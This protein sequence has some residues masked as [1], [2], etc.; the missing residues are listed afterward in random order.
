MKYAIALILACC[1]LCAQEK[2][3]QKKGAGAAAAR[4]PALRIESLS[5]F[6]AYRK[7]IC[8][9]YLNAESPIY[10]KG[11]AASSDE[12]AA[13]TAAAAELAKLQIYM[14]KRPV[15]IDA[16]RSGATLGRDSETMSEC[17]TK[18]FA[19]KIATDL[20]ATRAQLNEATIFI[21]ALGRMM[22]LSVRFE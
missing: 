6:D 19:A 11:E 7:S 4:T 5:Q 13:F 8:S 22:Q 17:Y 9:A 12:K 14:R 20:P 10:S 2:V 15:S 1:S 16:A 21:N 18:M 3:K